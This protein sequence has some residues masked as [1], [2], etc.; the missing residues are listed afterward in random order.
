MLKIENNYLSK[1]LSCQ[2]LNM[3]ERPLKYHG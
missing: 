3:N 1:L 2:Y